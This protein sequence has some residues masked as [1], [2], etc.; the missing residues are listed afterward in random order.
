MNTI[1]FDS[2]LTDE[3]RR[4]RLYDGQLFVLPP[5]RSS[6][7]LCAFADEMIRKAFAPLDPE[8][9][10]HELSVERYA[11]VLADLKPRFIN[12]PESKKYLQAILREAG[13]DLT[14]TYFDVPRMRSATSGNHLKTGIA[15]AWHPHRDTWYSAP[16]CQL[17]WWMPIYAIE[18]ANAM[19][20]H[21]RYW[22][23]PVAN[24]SE[25]YNYYQWN[26][27]HRPSASQHLQSDTRPLPRPTEKVELDP[28]LRVIAPPA[29]IL[30]FSGQQLHS[31]VPNTSGKTRFS[32]D[33]RTVNIE[34]VTAK[35]GAKN[36]DSACTGTSLRD[37]L[38]G[39][40]FARIPPDVI[41]LYNDGT[42]SEGEL[43]YV[44]A[45]A[46]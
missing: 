12:H 38:R 33:F 31:T 9:A 43:I 44:G 17:N 13:C 20:F 42:E 6:L 32:I 21:T 40:D 19:A 30:I 2:S 41:A 36:V 23:T 25:K 14:Q 34:D 29:G 1:Y 15:Y 37:F 18:S 7:A 4:T 39:S 16:F 46:V 5:T 26:Q 11:A 45:S 22:S 35:R 27:H 8:H 28:Q 10:Q 3:E 24:D